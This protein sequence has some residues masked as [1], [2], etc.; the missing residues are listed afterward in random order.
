MGSSI[1]DVGKIR[2]LMAYKNHTQKDLALI[3]GK[4]VNAVGQKL[5][6]VRPFTIK[7]LDQIAKSYNI[8]VNEL[9][10]S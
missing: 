4:S 8:K 1:I 7:E 5:N 3:I 6:G 2:A 9:L 10:K